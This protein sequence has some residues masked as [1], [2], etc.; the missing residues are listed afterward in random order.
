[1][2]RD[3]FGN[4][5]TVLFKNK[6]KEICIYDKVE[7]DSFRGKS[8]EKLTKINPV[9]H[10]GENILRFETRYK[11]NL[12]RQFKRKIWGYQLS[13]EKTYSDILKNWKTDYLSIKKKRVWLPFSSKKL[14]TDFNQY[15]MAIALQS[16]PEMVNAYINDPRLNKLTRSRLRGK[17]RQLLSNK[18]DELDSDINELNLK[19]VE[20]YENNLN[21][22]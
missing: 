6:Q 11:K 22:L 2:E 13:Q 5:Q 1:M 19:V 4:G 7:N 16:E 15:L 9:F 10:K 17:I 18:P 14:A 21:S 8:M 3:T 12:S 20:A